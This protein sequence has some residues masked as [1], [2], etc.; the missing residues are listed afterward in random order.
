[1]KTILALTLAFV[2]GACAAAQDSTPAPAT[3][4]APEVNTPHDINYAFGL[5]LGASLEGTGLDFDLDTVVQGLRDAMTKAKTPFGPERARQI[6]NSAIQ[7]QKDKANLKLEQKEKDYLKD[8]SKQK[9]VITTET[10]LQYEVLKQGTGEKPKVTDKVKVNYV[11]TFTDGKTFDS[12]VERG[13][14]VEFTLEQVI[15]AWKEGLQLMTVG[16]KYRFTVPSTLAYGDKGA[17]GVIPPYATLVFE[18]DLLAINPP[19]APDN[20][21][22]DLTSPPS[23]DKK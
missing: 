23:G 4:T 15:P 21:A 18:V 9:G 17:G 19:E 3:G 2:V 14:P 10:G 1:M 6:V 8:H 20:A 5:L 22:P 11:G 12:S 7:A 16:S 13:Q